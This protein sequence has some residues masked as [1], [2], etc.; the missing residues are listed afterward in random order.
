MKKK[1]FNYLGIFSFI[2]VTVFTLSAF[3]DNPE[4]PGGDPA[5]NSGSGKTCYTFLTYEC[6]T[7]GFG[8]SCQFTGNYGSP[9]E[10]KSVGCGPLGGVSTRKCVLK[11]QP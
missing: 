10:C 4:T 8:V 6:T 7:G 11:V 2:I 3:I 1:I 9:Y 5:G